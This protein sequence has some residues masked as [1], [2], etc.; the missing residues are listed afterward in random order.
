[1]TA[2]P[3]FAPLL[4][5]V[6]ALF[7]GCSGAPG[8]LDSASL[9]AIEQTVHRYVVAS[10]QGDA[11][12]LTA[13]YE[14][15]AILLPP[16]HEPIRGREAIGDFWAEGTDTGLELDTLRLEVGGDTAYLIGRYRLPPTDQEEADSG[17]Y[18]LCLKQQPDGVWKVA[19]DIWNGSGASDERGNAR[20]PR[21][22]SRPAA[23]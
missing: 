1:M 10:N 12:A 13:L 23:P 15:D 16:D 14:E 19:A 17:Q 22:S 7:A 3:G 9:G 11:A 5:G 8:A 20:E 2:R 21:I 6:A 4:A 18:V